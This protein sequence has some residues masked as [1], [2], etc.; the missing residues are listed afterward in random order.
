MR[1]INCNN[2]FCWL[3]LKKYSNDHYSLYN[4]RGC[5]GMRFGKFLNKKLVNEEKKKCWDNKMLKVL[6]Y[7]F[8]CFLGFIAFFFILAFF[9][10]FGCSY[11]FCK[12]YLERNNKKE[13]DDD[14][15]EE[16]VNEVNFDPINGVTN[17]TNVN[18]IDPEEPKSLDKSEILILIVLTILGIGMQPLYILFY[19]LLGLMECYR[20][21]N[22]WFYYY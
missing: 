8:S 17:E 5:P 14:D 4:F 16:S 10:C 20:R 9:A 6:W 21:F 2:E 7:L 18:N 22:C 11:E 13:S 1:C 3:C 12:C 19:L 15:D